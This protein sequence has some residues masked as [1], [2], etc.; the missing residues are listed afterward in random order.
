MELKAILKKERQRLRRC[1]RLLKNAKVMY[2][3]KGAEIKTIDL[4]DERN[5]D[6]VARIEVRHKI[7]QV[8]K[9]INHILVKRLKS[10]DVDIEPF[11]KNYWDEIV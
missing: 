6:I 8:N 4:Y 10:Q 11:M 7:R 1:E 9:A 5:S 3:K 2:W